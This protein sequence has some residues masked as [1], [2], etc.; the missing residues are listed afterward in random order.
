MDKGE[1]RARMRAVRGAVA[2]RAEK[3]AAICREIAAMPEFVRSKTVMF[4][5]AVG[6]EVDLSRAMETALD[7][8]KRVLAPVCVRDGVLAARDV[9]GGLK[10]GAFGI[11][12]PM[13]GEADPMEIDL[14]LCPGLAFDGQG[15]RLGY[16]KGYYDRFLP[17]TRAF[18]A[19]VCYTEC[20]VESVP[21]SPHDEPM[22]ALVS[23]RGILSIGGKV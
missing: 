8:G 18:F 11:L 14:I 23:E 9:R 17:R 7:G 10:R 16:G 13:G 15:R 5:L 1:L 22:R 21:V 3:D 20:I 12:E 2:D 6:S 19:G 4:Y